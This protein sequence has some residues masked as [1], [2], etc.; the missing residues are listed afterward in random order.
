MKNIGLTSNSADN[1]KVNPPPHL[2]TGAEE[3]RKICEI[4]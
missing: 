1:E 2:A 3:N 4:S